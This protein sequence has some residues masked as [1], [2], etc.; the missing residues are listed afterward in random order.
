[1]ERL[2]KVEVFKR[3]WV[4]R[5]KC[6]FAHYLTTCSLDP[7]TYTYMERYGEKFTLT[8][9]TNAKN[10]CIKTKGRFCRPNENHSFQMHY[11]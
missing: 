3:N 7:K 8:H 9:C 11:I 4:L 2:F 1:M 10:Y 6:T 5:M